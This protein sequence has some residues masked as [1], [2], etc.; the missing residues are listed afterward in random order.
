MKVNVNNNNIVIKL[1]TDEE[2]DAIAAFVADHGE[3]AL[4]KQFAVWLNSRIATHEENTK[5]GIWKKLSKVE[6]QE[7]RD[8]VR[9]R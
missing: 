2:K 8:R 5:A 1:E 6:R 7:L 9:N 4:E 3:I